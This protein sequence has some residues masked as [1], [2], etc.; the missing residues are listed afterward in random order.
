MD[1]PVP[2]H[3]EADETLVD[4]LVPNRQGALYHFQEADILVDPGVD[5]GE[6]QDHGPVE[7]DIDVAA[8][9]HAAT[10]NVAVGR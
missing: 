7:A 3:W 2:S 9:V 8:S 6:Q 1:N 5:R 10:G 4:S